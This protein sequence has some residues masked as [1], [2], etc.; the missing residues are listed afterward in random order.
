MVLSDILLV[1][2]L[3]A[4]LIVW[5][6]RAVPGR[7][8]LLSV[9]SVPALAFGVWG[10][11]DGDIRHPDPDLMV[12]FAETSAGDPKLMDKLKLWCPTPSNE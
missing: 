1:T 11:S 5:R 12:E 10:V 3:F 7:S 2:A 4:F 8:T 6:Q 9:F